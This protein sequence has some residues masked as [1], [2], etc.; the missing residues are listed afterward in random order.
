MRQYK[1]SKKNR[2]TYTYYSAAGKKLM[3]LIPGENGITE[4]DIAMLHEQDDL[5]YNA[6]RR[7]DYH[8]P[9]HY[10]SCIVSDGQGGADRNPYLADTDRRSGWPLRALRIS[11]RP[12]P[13]CP[14]SY[15]RFS[16][17]FSFSRTRSGSMSARSSRPAISCRSAIHGR[18]TT[19]SG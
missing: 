9:V 18:T 13:V 8:V 19:R 4:A 1:T 14:P 15:L 3:E 7:E 6:Q 12:R 11:R 16:A 2:A 10:D 17:P 5:E